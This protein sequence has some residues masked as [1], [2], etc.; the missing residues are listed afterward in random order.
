MEINEM[1]NEHWGERG[2]EGKQNRTKS[3]TEAQ[4]PLK[5]QQSQHLSDAQDAFSLCFSCSIAAR[6]TQRTKPLSI[7]T[8]RVE[9][10]TGLCA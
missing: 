3:G 1:D 10:K 9:G 5:K 7:S 8:A 4:T 2:R 6:K